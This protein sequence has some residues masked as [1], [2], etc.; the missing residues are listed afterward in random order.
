MTISST[1]AVIFD[2]DDTLFDH[3]Y[4]VRTA[5]AAMQKRYDCFA[6]VS[7]DEFEKLH[8]KLLNEIHIDRILTGDLSIEE[9]RALRFEL[10]F[11]YFDVEPTDEMKIEAPAFQR[12]KYLASNRLKPGAYEL[13]EEVKKY[14]K[15]GIVTNNLIDEQNRKLKDLG[16]EHLIDV[17]LTSEEAGITKPNPEI[18]YM[19]LNRLECKPSEAVMIGDSWES[20]IVGAYNIGMKCIWLNTYEEK[21]ETSGLAEE[22]STLEDK[23]YIFSLIQNYSN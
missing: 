14:Y 18:F 3:R 9:G 17:M 2:L 15:T 11:K 5:L 1:K 13:L 8:I 20:D 21:I 12:E 19:I 16:I 22:I 4:S 23:E 7:L 10:A 6:K